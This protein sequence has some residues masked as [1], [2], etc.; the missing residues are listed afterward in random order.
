MVAK[1]SRAF[2]TGAALK[3]DGYDLSTGGIRFCTVKF[4]Q[5]SLVKARRKGV[6]M[7]GWKKKGD[8]KWVMKKSKVF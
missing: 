7:P 8:Q 5:M 3:S 4:T 1:N 2:A 6:R